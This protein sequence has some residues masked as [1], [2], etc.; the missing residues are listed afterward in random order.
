MMIDRATDIEAKME[1]SNKSWYVLGIFGTFWWQNGLWNT[2]S[3]KVILFN[4]QHPSLSHFG[5]GKNGLS[6]QNTMKIE[7]TMSPYES[8][9]YHFEA[10][11][12]LLQPRQC[13]RVKGFCVINHAVSEQIPCRNGLGP[14]GELASACSNRTDHACCVCVWVCTSSY[15]S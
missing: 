8:I 14:W 2:R 6:I 15:A 10:W 9:Q 7:E 1:Q 11:T 3:Q 13:L 5:D 4:I 12:L